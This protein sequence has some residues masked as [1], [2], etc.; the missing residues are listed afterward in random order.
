MTK[1]AVI[2][3]MGPF[4][5]AG[6]MCLGNRK[7]ALSLFLVFAAVI[8]GFVFSPSRL[9]KLLMVMTYFSISI[10]AWVE[11]FQIARYGKK[12]IDTDARW[13]TVML[14]L[15]TGFAALPLLW[16]NSNFS[17]KSK[18]IWSVAV[19]L[20]AVVFFGLIFMYRDLIETALSNK[21]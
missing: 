9:I 12:K 11:T 15:F 7:K 18:V 13:Y 16:Q 20:L 4:P 17:K 6:H 5:G 19:P 10:P 14:L 1:T 8:S 2:F 21:M 3:L